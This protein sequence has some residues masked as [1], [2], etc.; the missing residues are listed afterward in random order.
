MEASFETLEKINDTLNNK[1][2]ELFIC[3]GKSSDIKI[4]FPA[5][6]YLN[7]NRNYKLGLKYFSV[8]NSIRNVTKANNK[9]KVD[10]NEIT[11]PPGSYELSSL[12]Y[13]FSKYSGVDKDKKYNV[14]F[15]PN[16]NLNKVELVLRNGKTVDFNVDNSINELLGF[17][18]KLYNENSTA[19]NRANI[20]NDIDA[21]NIHCDL[22]NGGYKNGKVENIIYSLPSFTVDLGIRILEI[23]TYPVYLTINKNIIQSINLL[24][25]DNK[26]RL[27]DFGNEKIMIQLHLKQV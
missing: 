21:I 24:I 14:E 9:I 22:I 6:I 2:E 19:E 26:A 4:Y 17:E 1:Y 10:N 7:P 8:Y 20:Q 12:N 15:V 27:I 5:P 13:Y 11:I 25:L 16:I 23:P 3:E 18:K